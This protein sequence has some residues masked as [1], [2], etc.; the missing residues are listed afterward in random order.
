MIRNIPDRYYRVLTYQSVDRVPDIEFGW[1]PQTI[2]R[3][4][5]EGMK[6]E[7]TPEQTNNGDSPI[8]AGHFQLEDLEGHVFW[9]HGGM[10]PTFEEKVLEQHAE[11][12]V[13]QMAGGIVAEKYLADSDQSSIPRFISFPVKSPDDWQ[14]IKQR[15]NPDDPARQPA[16]SVVAAARAAQ[17]RGDLMTASCPGFYWILRNWMG[18]E[19]LSMAFYDYPDMVHDMVE[20][21]SDLLVRSLRRFPDDILADEIRFDEDLA[22]RN[23]PLLSPAQFREFLQPGYHK[24]MAEAKRRGCEIGMVDSDG[25][26]K[27]IIPSWLEEGVNTMAPVEVAAGSDGPAWRKQFGKQV[28]LIGH[29][30]KRALIAGGS[31]IDKE[32][33]RLKPLLADGGFIPH[34]DHRVPPDVSYSNYCRYLEK[35]RKL[36]GR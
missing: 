33:E 7:M 21:F 24:V 3:W 19:N 18:T 36:I 17:A 13:I 8:V 6:L 22:Y 30:D 20:H 29:V 35:K 15:Y 1:W 32:L 14:N 11:S 26:P 25:D 31:A 4:L 34:V 28:R 5:K 10:N 9:P 23:G 2:R 27:A 12:V 16:D